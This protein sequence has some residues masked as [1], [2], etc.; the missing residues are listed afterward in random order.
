MGVRWLAT[1]TQVGAAFNIAGVVLLCLVLPLV[2]PKRQSA[3]Y[4]FT[5]FEPQHAE[6]R[7]ITNPL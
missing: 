2:A 6:A 7:G 1:I 4:V 3:R 5:S